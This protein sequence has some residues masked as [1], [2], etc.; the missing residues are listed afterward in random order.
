MSAIADRTGTVPPDYKEQMVS[1]VATINEA[2]KTFEDSVNVKTKSAI[3]AVS[4]SNIN[5][6]ITNIVDRMFDT[7]VGNETLEDRIMKTEAGQN[8]A[9][10]FKKL[11]DQ[12]GA[13]TLF[14]ERIPGDI[15]LG[16]TMGEV[17]S[18][19]LHSTQDKINESIASAFKSLLSKIGI[20]KPEPLVTRPR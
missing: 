4:I 12:F 2:L 1:A 19:Y 11:Q 17:A 15:D 8:R 5:E 20:G 6:S 18:E 10:A 9:Y 16:P 3:D 13:L 14:P 7:V